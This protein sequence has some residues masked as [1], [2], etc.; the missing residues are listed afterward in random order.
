M[1]R[2][3]R[4]IA[5][6]DRKRLLGAL[7]A[8]RDDAFAPCRMR[9]LALLAW[10]S[11][12][13]LQECLALDLE[14][15]ADRQHGRPA[16]KTI[17]YLESHQAKGGPGWNSGGQF[18]V[19]RSARSAL[20]TYIKTAKAKGWAFTDGWSGPVFVA[21]RRNGQSNGNHGRLSARAAQHS[22][23]DMQQAAGITKPYRFH[24]LR[25]DALT[26]FAREAQ[27]DPFKVAQFGRLADL[28]TAM[29][30]VHRSPVAAIADLAE[31]ATTSF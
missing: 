28:R 26:R 21:A 1:N 6:D 23:A 22:W 27:G 5:P 30:Y 11:A 15:L 17:G 19:T 24:D 29:R 16:I 2:P 14:Q 31:Q 13:R 7:R 12:L 9:A 10:G 20:A 8:T 3:G 25:H 4:S 18:V